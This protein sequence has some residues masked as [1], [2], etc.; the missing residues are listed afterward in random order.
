MTISSKLRAAGE[1]AEACERHAPVRPLVTAAI[2]RCAVGEDLNGC[3]T[4]G[5][6]IKKCD[7]RWRADEPPDSQVGRRAKS[8]KEYVVA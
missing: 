4:S 6:S 7:T 2:E 1:D 5:K 3:A 8:L